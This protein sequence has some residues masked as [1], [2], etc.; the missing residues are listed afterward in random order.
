[1]CELLTREEV[2]GLVLSVVKHDV[3]AGGVDQAVVL[4][5]VDVVL[6]LTIHTEDKPKEVKGWSLRTWG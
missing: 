5:Q 4:Q 2:L 3:V 6:D 1:M